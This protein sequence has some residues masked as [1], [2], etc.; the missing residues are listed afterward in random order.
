[1]NPFQ[2]IIVVESDEKSR[3]DYIYI[4]SIINEQYNGKLEN[5]VKVSPVFMRGKGNYKRVKGKIK[6][7]KNKYRHIGESFVV[8][9][10]DTDKFELNPEDNKVLCE[11]REYCT[12]NGYKFV[13][14]CH[15][16]EEVF[17]GKSVTRQD[18]TKT[19]ILYSQKQ[20]IKGI[21]LQCLKYNTLT[22]GKSNL[23][24]VLEE[25]FNS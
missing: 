9:C 10:F 13:W 6:D 11:E 25:L 12:V 16:I 14:F 5:E 19:A 20:G 17:I 18:K 21:N 24:I 15:D 3:S 23:L 7:L 4:K 22:K 1:M 2:I 8:Y